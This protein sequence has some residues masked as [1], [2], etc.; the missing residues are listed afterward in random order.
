MSETENLKFYQEQSTQNL[1]YEDDFSS[2]TTE[3]SSNYANETK[4]GS[5]ITMNFSSSAS[6]VKSGIDPDFVVAQRLQQA[7]QS[8][9]IE[10][11]EATAKRLVQEGSIPP[12]LSRIQCPSSENVIHTD[13]ITTVNSSFMSSSV[14][15]DSSF[16]P[17]TEVSPDG[18]PDVKPG[19]VSLATHENPRSILMNHRR[20]HPSIDIVPS[21]SSCEVTLSATIPAVVQLSDKKP[22]KPN[23]VG[24]WGSLWAPRLCSSSPTLFPRQVAE[25]TPISSTF[26]DADLMDVDVDVKPS[27]T[28]RTSNNTSNIHGVN[29]GTSSFTVD[30]GLGVDSGPMEIDVTLIV[31]NSETGSNSHL[32]EVDNYDDNSRSTTDIG[33]QTKDSTQ[34]PSFYAHRPRSPLHFDGMR[35]LQLPQFSSISQ[36]IILSQLAT[37]N[38]DLNTDT[39]GNVS[40]ISTSS[41]GRD[42]DIEMDII[43]GD[44]D[45]D[46]TDSG[47]SDSINQAID[48]VPLGSYLKS[49]EREVEPDRS[50]SELN[51]IARNLNNV[52]KVRPLRRFGSSLDSIDTEITFGRGPIVSDSFHNS[53]KMSKP[54]GPSGSLESVDMEANSQPDPSYLHRGGR[55]MDSPETPA[56]DVVA[57]VPALY[58]EPL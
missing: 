49:D 21:P 19:V 57:P 37:L 13:G 43:S 39:I 30:D 4:G 2:S 15:K 8:E 29:D 17:E 3:P 31:P 25:V 48:L 36:E 45:V 42:R 53:Y 28:T 40:N 14:I 38:S 46:M 9:Q 16:N 6:S 18:V 20:Q 55:D 51:T 47:M 35:G 34:F 7:F 44:F 12:L 33:D 41:E 22:A 56:N 32:M 52:R 23:I 11:N 5:N 10:K 50:V 1:N 27:L 24:V 58:C 26:V 54:L